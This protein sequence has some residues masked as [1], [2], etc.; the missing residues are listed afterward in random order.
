MDTIQLF[1]DMVDQLRNGEVLLAD[2]EEGIHLE[3]SYESLVLEDQN[4]R[5][6]ISDDELIDYIHLFLETRRTARGVPMDLDFDISE[7]L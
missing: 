2:F 5:M 1:D 3:I 6:V 4:S 7:L